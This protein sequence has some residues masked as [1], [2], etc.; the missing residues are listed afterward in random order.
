MHVSAYPQ[1]LLLN[2]QIWSVMQK[3]NIIIA[4][5]VYSTTYCFGRVPLKVVIIL[6]NLTTENPEPDLLNRLLKCL[7][8]QTCTVQR[9]VS[10]T[11]KC[12]QAAKPV[13]TRPAIFIHHVSC[14]CFWFWES[15]TVKHA[16]SHR[17]LAQIETHNNIYACKYQIDILKHPITTKKICIQEVTLPHCDQSDRGYQTFTDFSGRIVT[18]WSHCEHSFMCRGEKKLLIASSSFLEPAR[19]QCDDS[20][21]ASESQKQK[22]EWREN[23]SDWCQTPVNQKYFYF[24]IPLAGL[25]VRDVYVLFAGPLHYCFVVK[26]THKFTSIK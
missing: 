21:I 24:L 16:N 13:Q 25:P 5:L 1:N 8:T 3:I 2:S 6:Y 19:I 20:L 15:P 18:R 10:L 11:V 9:Y 22:Q 7:I 26:P 23:Q 14:W 12:L 17:P 4:K